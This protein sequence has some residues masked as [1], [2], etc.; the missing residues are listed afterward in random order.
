[1]LGMLLMYF[2]LPCTVNKTQAFFS[3]TFL[4]YLFFI[5]YW[6]TS[7]FYCDLHKHKKENICPDDRQGEVL[8]QSTCSSKNVVG[9]FF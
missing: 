4:Y 8:N 7:S 1:M 3:G 2:S 6:F 5:S 9:R